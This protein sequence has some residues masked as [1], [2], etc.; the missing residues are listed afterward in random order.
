MILYP[1]IDIKDGKC[2]RLL[3]GDFAH[4]TIFNDSPADQAE[5][6]VKAGFKWLHL[7]DL[8]GAVEGKPVNESAVKDILSRVD[9]PVQL[10]G[11]IRSMAQIERWIDAGLSRIILGTV[12][13]K[14]PELVHK[15]CKAFP[16]KIAVGIDARK[17]MVAVEGWLEVSSVSA[18]HLARQY[19]DAGV[20]A[21]IYTDIGRDGALLGPNIEETALMA[22]SLTIPVI[23]SGG[24]TSISDL[25]TIAQ[26]SNRNIEGAIIG[27]A[28]Y[29]GTITTDEIKGYL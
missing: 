20:V 10:G 15:A 14:Q 18:L 19:E 4:T 6:F 24:V 16:G 21:L 11:G 12:A 26:F 8:D 29:E 5:K 9:I 7:V 28:L 22:A 1:A 2:V 25:D 27:R 3:R 23:L 17:G 13:L